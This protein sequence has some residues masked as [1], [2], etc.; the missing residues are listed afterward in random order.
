MVIRGGTVRRAERSHQLE[1]AGPTGAGGLRIQ[2]AYRVDPNER[3]LPAGVAFV[4]SGGR[5]AKVAVA[6]ASEV[7]H[8]PAGE[9]GVWAADRPPA[10]AQA[11]V[12][13]AEHDGAPASTG[14]ASPY[15]EGLD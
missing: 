9:R 15:A 6:R 3:S 2:D 7:A 10:G 8:E 14:V 4:V 13:R 1:G 11:Q 5:A 12:P